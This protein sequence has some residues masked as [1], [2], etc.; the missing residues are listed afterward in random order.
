MPSRILL[1]TDTVGGVWRY[2]LEI[3]AGFAAHGAAVTLV[4]MGPAPSGGQ[5]AEVAGLAGVELLQTTLPL[6]WLAEN[7]VELEQASHALA[8]LAEQCGAETIQLHTPALAMADWPAPVVAVMHSCVGTWWRAV[9]AGAPLPSDMMW[10]AQ[11]VARG[12]PCADALIAPS[13]AFAAEVRATYDDALAIHAIPNGRRT[14]PLP[15]DPQPHAL[16]VGR[17]WDEG[18]NI[19]VLD[20][21]AGASGVP[22]RAAGAVRGPNGASVTCLNLALLGSLN[23]T[24]LA[25]EYARAAVFVS[26]ARYEPFGLAV[27]EAARAG[28]ALLLSDIPTFR[29]LWDGAALFVHPDE[30]DGLAMT[31]RELL[32]NP[33]RC[34]ALGASARHRSRRYTVA[35]MVTATWSVHCNLWRARGGVRPRHAA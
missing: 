31:L 14:V 32:R 28:A 27:L 8:G 12:L 10:R 16:T 18:K 15:R 20:Q 24:T 25:Q 5:C 22:V 2:S 30:P 6:D 9:H 3:A 26:P 7:R 23:D 17:L 33:D 29:Q 34:A 35:R 21:A 4:T 1:T 13:E 19:G 11:C